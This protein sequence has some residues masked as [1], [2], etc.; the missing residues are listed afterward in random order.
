MSNVTANYGTLLDFIEILGI[1][2]HYF[3]KIS[4]IVCLVNTHIVMCFMSHVSTSNGRFSGFL[5]NG[6]S[7]ISKGLQLY[8]FSEILL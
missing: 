8:T 1:F 2:I 7:G 6:K 5:G 4:R 3:T